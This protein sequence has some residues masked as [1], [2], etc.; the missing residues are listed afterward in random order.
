MI[1]LCLKEIILPSRRFMAFQKENYRRL[2]HSCRGQSTVGAPYV[3]VIGFALEILLEELI[4]TGKVI[5]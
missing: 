4:R 3:R 2:R 5:R 1:K